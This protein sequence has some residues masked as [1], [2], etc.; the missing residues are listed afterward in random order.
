MYVVIIAGEGLIH[1]LKQFIELI[2]F[3]SLVRNFL[4]IMCMV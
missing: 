2:C 3:C 4:N 1:I